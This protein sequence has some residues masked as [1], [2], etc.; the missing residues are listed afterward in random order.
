MA[1]T[2]KELSELTEEKIA[3]LAKRGDEKAIAYLWEGAMPR[4]EK[5]ASSFCARYPWLDRDDLSQSILAEF[6]KLLRR[7]K[8]ELS[9]GWAKYLYHTLYRATQDVLRAE[10][11]LGI[12][13]PHKRHYPSWCRLSELFHGETLEDEINCGLHRLDRGQTM[14]LSPELPPALPANLRKSVRADS[15]YHGAR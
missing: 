3:I 8:P 13:Y 14:N 7:Y 1:R 5:I 4:A 2:K 6:P 9:R 11:P 10:D 12:N 15:F